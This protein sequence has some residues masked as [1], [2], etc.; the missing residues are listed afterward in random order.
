MPAFLSPA[1]LRDRSC[2]STLCSCSRWCQREVSLDFVEV[3]PQTT[4]ITILQIYLRNLDLSRNRP[5]DQ[6]RGACCQASDQR[7]LQG[8]AQRA[9]AGEASFDETEEEESQDC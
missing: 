9:C 1:D 7:R 5:R 8:A 6:K 2:P 4:V 3:N